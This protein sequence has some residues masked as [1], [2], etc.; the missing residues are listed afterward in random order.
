MRVLVKNRLMIR[1]CL[2]ILTKQFCE[3]GTFQLRTS[4]IEPL[5]HC[6]KAFTQK[7]LV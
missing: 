2:M 6:E 7:T 1:F 4:P 5:N 3:H